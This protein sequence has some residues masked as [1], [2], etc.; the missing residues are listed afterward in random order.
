MNDVKFYYCESLDKYLIGQRCDNFYYAE[1]TPTGD[2]SYVMSRYLP[3]GQC[4]TNDYN[5]WKDH[6]YPSEP[7]EIDFCSWIK[8]FVENVHTK[9]TALTILKAL[10]RE[11]RPSNDI[12]GNKTLVIDRDDFESIRHKYLD[13][14]KEEK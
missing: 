8:G 6:T 11:M 7:I 4:V 13:R 3:W 2:I 9:D 1:I 14:K 5:L 12:F 10:S